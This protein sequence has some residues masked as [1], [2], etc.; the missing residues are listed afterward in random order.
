MK[1]KLTRVLGSNGNRNKDQEYLFA[2]I[3]K[4]TRWTSKT[5]RLMQES[6][7]DFCLWV[8]ETLEREQKENDNE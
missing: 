4:R 8:I 5:E 6:S 3:L 7:R 2:E 1:P